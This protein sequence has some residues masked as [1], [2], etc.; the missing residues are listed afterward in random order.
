M[1]KKVVNIGVLGT[2]RIGRLHIENIM[3]RIPE[4]RVAAVVDVVEETARR[5]AEEFGIRKVS[6]NPEDVFSDPN[7]EAVLICTSTD[8]HADL[9][10][11]AAEAGKHIFC[12]KPIALN[13]EEIDRA[14]FAV[15]KNRVKFM[16][17]F[18]RRFDPNFA[19]AKELLLHGAIGKPELLRI[20]SRDPAP[21]SL[22]YIRRS[23]GMFLD[24]TIHDFDMACFLL[25]EEVVEV[26]A[27]GEA[28][29]DPRIKEAEDI[30]TAVITLRFQSGALGV[31]DNSRRA[32]Y[33]YDQRVEILG[34]KGMIRV[35]NPRPHTVTVWN[36]SGEN[37]PTLFSFFMDR[38]TEAFVQELRAF[39]SSL[40]EGR[41]PPVSGEEGRRPV[42]LALAAKKS[43]EEKRPVRP[44]E[45]DPRR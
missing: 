42:V 37:G 13:L 19:K 18:N 45:V 1:K 3:R 39:V 7:I 40:C 8:T 44:S 21:P 12:E 30:D 16:V 25:G 10:V 20:T 24:M 32:A 41:D 29:V 31:I 26:Y 43:L 38:Y 11:A 36:T 17:G 22:D 27:V 2:G 15:Q 33:G 4:A 14:L 5:C 6:T 9:I 23:G 35:E 34:E 28:L